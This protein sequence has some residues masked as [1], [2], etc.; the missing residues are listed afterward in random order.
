MKKWIFSD[1][2]KITGP[3]G[4]AESQDIIKNNPSLYAWNPSFTHWMPVT[5]IEDF[6][7]AIEIPA[8]PVDVPQ[9]LLGEFTNEEQ[10]LIAQLGMLSE[11]LNPEL[12][13]MIPGTEGQQLHESV[14]PIEGETLITKNYPNSFWNTDLEETLKAKGIEKLIINSS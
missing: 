9:E 4:L 13:F 8:P 1:N 11:N 2:G 3:F 10:E 7:L 12:P 6:E 5:H 14:L